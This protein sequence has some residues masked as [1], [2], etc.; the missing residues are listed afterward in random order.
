MLDRCPVIMK[1]ILLCF[2]TL[3]V[4][5]QKA[6]AQ[7]IQTGTT[8]VDGQQVNAALLNNLANNAVILP[9]FIS[10]KS[11]ATPATTDYLV[12]YQ[13]SDGALHKTQVSGIIA[14]AFAN[15]A[16]S[17]SFTIGGSWLA[18][19]PLTDTAFSAQQDNYS[20][21]NLGTSS[22]LRLST[23]GGNVDLTGIA[24]QS[25]GT[26]IVIRNIGAAGN[27]VLK[28]QD[29]N[30]TAA[31]EFIFPGGNDVSILPDGSFVVIYD[32]TLTAWTPFNLSG[33]SGQLAPTFVTI[34]PSSNTATLACDAN[35]VSQNAKVTL[36]GNTQL[37]FTGLSNGMTGEL[38]VAQDGTGS[39]K[40]YLPGTHLTDGSAPG[41][42]AVLTSVTAS[43][44]STDVGDPIFEPGAAHIP[45]GTTIS[46]ISGNTA[47]LSATV[48]VG[49]NISFYLPNRQSKTLD[50]HGSVTL[51]TTAAAMD[52]LA[53]SY[54]GTNIV[55]VKGL[56]AN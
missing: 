47:T 1:R 7:D 28:N 6:H 11:N 12:F 45:A 46:S 42:T 5:W 49:T 32:A 14:T 50:G 24:A 16:T 31:N 19:N 53:W 51:T 37:I 29:A 27:I 39:R 18:S 40:L 2:F 35:K 17:G 41:S 10:G 20:P 4:L 13:V 22:I 9:T 43:W 23:T 56:N 3:A 54:D 25:D 52:E 55:W 36:T 34:T 26:I 33:S 21:A 15:A 44:A 48:A 30:S 8:F 38:R